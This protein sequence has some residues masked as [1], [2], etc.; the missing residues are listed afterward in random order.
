METNTAYIL[1]ASVLAAFGYIGYQSATKDI[2]DDDYL[3]SR[4]TRDGSG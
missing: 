1:T 3:S 2:D 4:G